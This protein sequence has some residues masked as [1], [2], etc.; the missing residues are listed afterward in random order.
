M[1]GN[2]WKDRTRN[3]KLAC[4]LY[5]NQTDR[6]RLEGRWQ[7][8]RLKRIKETTNCFAINLRSQTR[9]VSPWWRGT[10]T[11]IEMK[12]KA[13]G[14]IASNKFNNNVAVRGGSPRT[15]VVSPTSAD[16]LGRSLAYKRDALPIGQK[17]AAVP[18]GNAVA[19]TLAKAGRELGAQSTLAVHSKASQA[20][21]SERMSNDAFLEAEAKRRGL[22]VTELLMLKQRPMR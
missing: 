15:E 8:Y 18:L 13:G 4:V 7:S 12:S 17:P 20:E 3:Q 16:Q 21:R 9:L 19:L 1:R 5:P 14:G 2:D 10:T 22:S 11:E 6:R